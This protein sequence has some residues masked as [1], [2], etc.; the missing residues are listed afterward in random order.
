MEDEAR[1]G[2]S[3]RV[4]DTEIGEWKGDSSRG[5]LV[6]KQSRPW[7]LWTKRGRRSQAVDITIVVSSC[8]HGKLQTRV[9]TPFLLHPHCPL[10]NT[11]PF[12]GMMN[13][14]S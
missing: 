13:L 9:G 10:P 2:E 12:E 6:R 14:P 5:P 8:M 11:A 7:W 3:A 1:R 4:N